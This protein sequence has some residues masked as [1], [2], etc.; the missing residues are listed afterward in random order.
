VGTEGA[1]GEARQYRILGVLGEGGFGRVYRARLDGPQGFSKEV[2]IK[3]IRDPGAVEHMMARFRDEARIL[4][5]I[6]DRA[7]V[8]VDPPTRLGGTWAVV[9]ELVEGAST[10]D[11]LKIGPFPVGIALEIVQEV[12]RALDV[13]YHQAGPDGAPLHLLHRDIKPPNIQITASGTVKLLDFGVARATFAGREARTTS[14]IGGT[15]GY[16]APERILGEELHAGDVFS[17]GVVL[18]Q[19]ITGRHPHGA[20]DP[21]GDA[22]LGDVVRLSHRMRAEEAAE[23]PTAAEVERECA[24]LLRRWHGG[25]L[26]EWAREAVRRI[27]DLPNDELVGTTLTETLASVPRAPVSVEV[28]RSAMITGGV[29]L[30]ASGTTLA[31]AG[32]VTVV[33]AGAGL[34]AWLLVPAAPPVPIA[35]PTAPTASSP[36]GHPAPPLPVVAA[37]EPAIPPAAAP[38]APDKPPSRPAPAPPAPTPAPPA[39]APAPAV[40]PPVPVTLNSFPFGAKVFLDGKMVGETP[41]MSFP[42]E[43]GEHTLTMEL[44]GVTS[45]ARKLKIGS[46]STAKSYRWVPATGTWETDL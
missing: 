42:V 20:T 38:P 2:A 1:R 35:P 29:A 17:L 14:S 16:I 24:D 27:D 25:R 15:P 31:V 26:R 41:L 18:Y 44:G 34:A 13:V 7:I 30:L 12:A 10:H 22:L 45:S 36:L 40:G 28:P 39:P 46:K 8:S 9:M 43:P 32:L 23:R 4:G 19:L 11:L 3:L 5:L 21:A 6:R 33:I 37:P